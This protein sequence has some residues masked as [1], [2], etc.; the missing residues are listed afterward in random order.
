MAIDAF[1]GLAS[2]EL[3][4]DHDAVEEG[5]QPEPVNL[6]SLI[7]GVPIGDER[8]QNALIPKVAKGLNSP[9]ERPDCFL[10]LQGV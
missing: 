3:A 8:Q 9:R 4:L 2:A 10:S 1:I 5:S 7:G 6:A